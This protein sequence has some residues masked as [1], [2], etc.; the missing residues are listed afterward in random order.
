M[1]QCIT[2]IFIMFLLFLSLAAI[3]SQVKK[4]IQV[5]SQEYVQAIGEHQIL[6]CLE[7]SL[8]VSI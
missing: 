2:I 5:L 7:L 3:E 6:Q 8:S 1:V 4:S